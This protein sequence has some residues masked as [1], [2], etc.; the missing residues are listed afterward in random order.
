MLPWVFILHKASS[1]S[2]KY[3]KLISRSVVTCGYAKD[4][5]SQELKN[6]EDTRDVCMCVCMYVCMCVY[7]S[8]YKEAWF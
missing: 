8:A 7:V 2:L 1:L 3:H 6:S 5:L 4:C